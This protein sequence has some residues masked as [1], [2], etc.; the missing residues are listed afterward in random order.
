MFQGF[1]TDLILNNGR[2]ER[3]PLEFLAKATLGSVHK[4]VILPAFGGS[5][6]V[7]AGY[8]VSPGGAARGRWLFHRSFRVT[9]GGVEALETPHVAL[10]AQVLLLR[11]L[12]G[13]KAVPGWHDTPGFA[14]VTDMRF[15]AIRLSGSLGT[16]MV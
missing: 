3:P 8:P 11:G 13:R 7:R 1:R 10:Y 6:G 5:S 14:G 16:G 12:R 9:S 2:I 15:G 4:F